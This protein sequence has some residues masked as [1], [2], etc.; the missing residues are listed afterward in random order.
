VVRCAGFAVVTGPAAVVEPRGF[1]VVGPWVG[2]AVVGPFAVVP[3]V[4]TAGLATGVAGFGT[5]L[6]VTF[7]GAG[8][9]DFVWA[10]AAQHPNSRTT[11]IAVK[12]S[13][14][15]IVRTLIAFFAILLL[16]SNVAEEKSYWRISGRL[17]PCR[18][19]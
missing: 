12:Y 11:K 15:K 3:V 18:H 7:G 5:V 16:F 2:L 1:A 13:S 19:Q 14:E 9:V 8:V 6:V 17:K 10:L 4:V